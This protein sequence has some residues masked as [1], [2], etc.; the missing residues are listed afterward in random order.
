M[1]KR[2]RVEAL[3]NVGKL[4]NLVYFQTF[5]KRNGITGVVRYVG[6]DEEAEKKCRNY[7]TKPGRIPIF[8]GDGATMKRMLDIAVK[9]AENNDDEE[10]CRSCFKVTNV[11]VPARYNVSRIAEYIK[12]W[13]EQNL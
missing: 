6:R 11:M 3:R 5:I 12:K 9:A 8:L 4:I 1:S 13:D 7:K 10:L 2:G